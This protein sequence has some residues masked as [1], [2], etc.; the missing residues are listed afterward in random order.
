MSDKVIIVTAPDDVNV[1]G[2]RVL[3]VD[4]YQN[5]T[6]VLSQALS[7]LN[8]TP[9][10]ISY[11]WKNEESIDWLIDKKHKSDLIIFNADSTNDLITGYM[12]AQSNSYYFGTLRSLHLVNKSAITAVDHFLEAMEKL[13]FNHETR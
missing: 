11:V 7:Q 9:T 12:A 3:L 4:L 8:N 5:Q 2:I 6:H 1:D 10:I 13:I